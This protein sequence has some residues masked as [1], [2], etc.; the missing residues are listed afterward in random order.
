MQYN[1]DKNNYNVAKRYAKALCE[2]GVERD[3]LENF[4]SDLELVFKTIK[5]EDDLFKTL[6]AP[7]VEKNVK[8]EILKELF[9]ER[10]NSLVLD[11][12]F[13]LIDAQHFDSFETVIYCFQEFKDA[14]NNILNVIITSAVELNELQKE[15]LENELKQKTGKMPKMNYL[16]DSS[17][18]AGLIIDMGEYIIDT[19]LANQFKKLEKQLI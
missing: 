10:I 16:I 7:S 9:S 5:S 4:M 3:L 13:V 1:L 2:L 19:S 6:V 17:I 14:E 15:N 18:I 11:F 12:L 8:K